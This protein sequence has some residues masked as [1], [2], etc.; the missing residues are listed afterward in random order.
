MATFLIESLT[1]K[2]GASLSWKIR[3]FLDQITE[4]VSLPVSYLKFIWL[5]IRQYKMESDYR[6][7][8]HSDSI[9]QTSKFDTAKPIT[10]VTLPKSC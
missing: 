10:T 3:I 1:F 5:S 8:V 9:S 6:D 4:V 2:L 7:Y